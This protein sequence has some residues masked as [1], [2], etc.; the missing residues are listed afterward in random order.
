[1]NNLDYKKLSSTV[2]TIAKEAGEKILQ[3]YDES[4]IGIS[5]KDDNS[6]LTKADKAAND[7]I[8][9]G[10][11]KLTPSIPILSNLSNAISTA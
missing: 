3:I 4:D 7:I 8:E 1:M 9:C 2:L 6:P 11:K 5:Y 10:L